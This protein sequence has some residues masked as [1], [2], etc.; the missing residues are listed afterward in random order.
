[1]RC[2]HCGDLDDKVVDSRAGDDGAA[3]RRRRECLACGRRF[4][5]Y[6]RVE[7]VPL[8]VVKRSG[9]REPFD[10]RKLVAGIA[11]AAKNRPVDPAR[12]QAIAA[13]VEELARI[14]GGEVA[15][16][17]VGRAVLDALRVVDEVAYLRFAS[18]Y[19]GF[20]GAADFER[21]VDA[22]SADG[23]PVE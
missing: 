12:M 23:R 8:V 13:D 14:E 22:L 11:S 2:P 6:E 10:R 9:G 19:K 20:D 17:R 16:D 5:T 4:T 3:I 18:V 21:E 15:S 1:M 7:E